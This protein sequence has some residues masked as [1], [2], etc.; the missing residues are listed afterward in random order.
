M[1]TCHCNT[2][3]RLSDGTAAGRLL[4]L[5]NRS[6]YTA[7]NEKLEV[8]KMRRFMMIAVAAA[9]VALPDAGRALQPSGDPAH[10]YWLTENGKG[11]VRFAP[12]GDKT[13][14]D[15]VWIADPYDE[16]GRPKRDAQNREMCGLRLVGELEQAGTGKWESGWIYNP[17]SGETFS[18]EVRTVSQDQLR[19]R[20]YLGVRLLGQ[21]QTWT[22][23]DSDRGGC[24]A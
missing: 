6:T 22:R 5:A 1:Q 8:S 12:C 15:M 11:I 17:R 2:K 19:V 18:A 14:G 20:G 24:S 23:V 10:G 9:A 3:Q 21:T 7:L 13:C 4:H 16:T